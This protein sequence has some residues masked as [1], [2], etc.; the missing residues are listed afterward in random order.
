ML[1][2]PRKGYDMKKILKIALVLAG[3]YGL[4]LIPLPEREREPQKASGTPFLWDRD[5]LWSNLEKT[6]NAGKA[7]QPEKL[8]SLVWHMSREID[9]VLEE[10][11]GMRVSAGDAFY[12]VVDS[13]F[14]QIAPLIAAQQDKSDW[15]IRFYDRVRKKLKEDAMYWYMKNPGARQLSYSVLYGI[16][17]AV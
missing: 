9:S 10:Y 12:P 1:R 8:D 2:M 11:E 17:A 4:L 13:M 16:R 6:F 15:Y 5:A 3:I 14:F 7:M